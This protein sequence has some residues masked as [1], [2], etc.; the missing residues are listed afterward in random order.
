MKDG[1][2]GPAD[3]FGDMVASLMCRTEMPRFDDP[4]P[5]L[6][7]DDARRYPAAF[8]VALCGGVHPQAGIADSVLEEDG[9]TPSFFRGAIRRI[10]EELR[11]AISDNPELLDALTDAS[12]VGG[13]A[14]AD[15]AQQRVWAVT[16]PEGVGVAG[17]WAVRG[18]ELQR[19]RQ[20][21]LVRPN[22]A[23]LTDPIS[24]VLV[25]ANVVVASPATGTDPDF[26]F[27]HP[28]PLDIAPEA[29]EIA[30]GLRS[31]DSAVGFELK[32]HPEWRGPLSVVLSVSTTRRGSDT[33]ARDLVRNVMAAI[34]PLRNLRVFAF[35]E[36]RALRLW[37]TA[38]APVVADPANTV[39]GV[40][41]SYGRHY[42]FLKAIAALWS[43]CIDDKIRA[44][45]KIDL[46][47]AFPQEKL[48][49]ETGQ[50]AFEHFMTPRW[51]ASAIGVDGSDLDL[52]LI[53]GGLVNEADIEMSLFTPDVTPAA[54]ATPEDAIFSSRLP[55]ALSTEFEIGAGRAIERVHVTGGASGI[56]V[57]GLRRWRLFTPSVVG[58]AEDQAYLL[59]GLGDL[60]NRPAY[61]HEP[62]LIMRHDKADL[63]PDLI[64]ASAGSNHIGDLL[65]MRL[66]SAYAGMD[67]KTLLDPFSGCFVS[68]LPLAITSL[69]FALHALHLDS[70]DAAAAYLR[71]GTKR[72]EESDVTVAALDDTV[73]F[74]REGWT[75]F[76]DAL[77]LIEQG[78]DR[79]DEGF[80]E[81]VA[82]AR[83]VV[84]EAELAH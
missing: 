21:N 8:L 47:Q 12:A 64:K 59:S 40:E 84:R 15:E 19:R 75:A 25:T 43:V 37:D 53:A 28:I 23:P 17:N 18:S 5:F 39:F 4:V 68:R 65:R 7:S 83:T 52:A 10:G 3:L 36:V 24:S 38:I 80:A 11:T 30:H 81:L 77:D 31:L 32:R 69:R 61:V 78:V 6:E 58:R 51:G 74:E 79:G 66:F 71:E 22:P 76:Y 63:I 42:S 14:D 33:T 70:V 50:S 13:I 73:R 27:D 57:A 20:L 41:G 35:D 34:G 16:F 29:T 44:T 46:D 45:F 48:V 60:A 62:G 55:Q 9:S 72:L 56:L 26:W 49:A 1:R 67:H 82:A 54:L 2:R